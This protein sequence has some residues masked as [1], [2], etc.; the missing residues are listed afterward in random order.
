M[1]PLSNETAEQRLQIRD[2]L[3]AAVLLIGFAF[4]INRGIEIKGLYMDDLY[5]WSCYGEQ[6]FMEYVFPMGSTRFR[7]LYYLAAWLEL[8]LVG[9]HINW[10][11]PINILL[12]GLLAF[13]LYYLGRRLAGRSLPGFLAGIL[14]LLS[15]MSYYQIGQMYG[16]ME[17]MALWMAV[18]IL[19]CLYRYLNDKKEKIWYFHWACWLYLGICFVHE[20]YMA[21]LPLFYLVLGLRRRFELR[22][23]LW[24]AVAF[25]VVQVVRFFTI[26]T[27]SPAGTGGTQVADTF[28]VFAAIKYALSQ[29]AYIFGINAGPEHLNGIA[30]G[31]V[32]F[33][34]KLLVY[35][36]DAVLLAFVC[37]F[38]AVVI[39]DKERR[40]RCLSNAAL[41]L[42][43]IALCIGSSSVTVRVEMRWVYVSYAAALLFLAYICGVLAPPA[44]QAEEPFMPFKRFG[45]G[46]GARR[47]KKTVSMQQ[48]GD[49]A[50]ANFRA[51][52]SP[53]PVS[54]KEKRGGTAVLCCAGFLL[55]LL[56][57]LPAEVF[58]RGHY[59]NLY[60][61]PN[62]SRYNSL[63]EETYERYGD[64]I[65]GKT[66]YIL[67]NSYEMSDFTAETFFK[68]YDP[69][70][71]AEGTQVKHIEGIEEFGLVT[72][73]MLILREDPEHDGFQDITRFVRDLKLD[74]EYGLYDDGWLD[75]EGSF[76]VL[77]GQSG[78]VA[79]TFM[80]PGVLSGGEETEIQVNG[81]PY[82]TIPVTESVYYAE[83]PGEAGERLDIQI[84]NNFYMQNAQEQRGEKRLS[85]LVEIA[86]D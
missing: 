46:D 8:A 10:I 59:G 11:V 74:V 30:W 5:L 67:G 17:T 31:D 15:R 56:L 52:H 85:V 83:I 77:C 75:E 76:T 68:V 80:Y 36:A 9:T 12:N 78:K 14:F 60:L 27:L 63:A 13:Y 48:A 81:E 57:M 25:A 16:L 42:T 61:W 35:G 53:A 82:V 34:I 84:R 41:F 3:M 64:D 73:Q 6:S 54:R 40:G 79:F 38:L 24:P 58:F 62:Q 33:R 45:L 26:G 55:Y 72:D 86:S 20:R 69:K 47:E 66:I 43:F 18:G 7:F 50:E 51:Q 23:W 21:L 39:R 22:K 28:S 71:K 37:G 29:V 44:R 2:D 19:W 32:P 70:R 4:L 49:S 65:F 1:R